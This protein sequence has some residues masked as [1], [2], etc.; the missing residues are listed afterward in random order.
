MRSKFL[1]QGRSLGAAELDWLRGAVAAHPEWSRKRLAREVCQRWQWWTPQ[2]KMKDFAARSLLLKLQ[3]RGLLSLPPLREQYRTRR[4]ELPP[5]ADPPPVIPVG[6]EQP[7]AGVQP[8]RWNLALAGS[9]AEARVHELQ[10]AAGQ[11]LACLLFGAAAWQSAARDR[12]I[13]WS[14]AQR[15]QGLGLVTNNTRFLIL[16]WVK[17]P[18]LA[19]HILSRAVR[20]LRQDWQGKYGHPVWLVETFVDRD[21]FAG[22]AYDAANW[23]R[24]GPT[25]GRGRQGPDPRVRSTS[26]KELFVC[27]LHR[28]FRQRLQRASG[29]GPW[30]AEAP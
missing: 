22:T 25:Q 28:H 5:P 20:R 23:Q 11:D 6:I 12:F 26:I 24:M 9:W 27:P 14:A 8:L 18:G 1:C 7:L 10:S 13:G 21:R 3:A 29:F 2:G 4:W 16:P 15:V 30:E 19:S 17:V